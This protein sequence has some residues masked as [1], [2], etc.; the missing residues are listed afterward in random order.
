MIVTAALLIII[1]IL[2]YFAGQQPR[3][4]WSK[5]G[6]E[7]TVIVDVSEDPDDYGIGIEHV[8]LSDWSIEISDACL[9]INDKQLWKLWDAMQGLCGD[10]ESDA[11]SDANE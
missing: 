10:E 7:V 8:N 4:W 11:A 1:A 3:G 9:V 6:A 5:A 2:C